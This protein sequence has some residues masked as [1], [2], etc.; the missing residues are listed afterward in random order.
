MGYGFDFEA[1]I[2]GVLRINLPFHID[3]GD[4]R[5]E[6]NDMCRNIKTLYNFKPPATVEEIQAAAQQYVRTVSGFSKPSAAN[7]RAFDAAVEAVTRSTSTLLGSLLTDASPKNR[8]IE[9][10]R[11]HARAV[12]RFG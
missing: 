8:D 3:I 9:A 10:A 11:A 1:A 12:Q 2:I 4:L 5:R 6:G 7:Q